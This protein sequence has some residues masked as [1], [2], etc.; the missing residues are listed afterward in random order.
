M[1]NT[2]LSPGCFVRRSGFK[3]DFDGILIPGDFG[4]VKATNGKPT[5]QDFG[6]ETW[7]TCTKQGELVAIKVSFD[8]SPNIPLHLFSPQD[9][10]RYHNQYPNTDSMMDTQSW[11]CFKHEESCD[12]DLKIICLYIELI[13]HLFY[14]YVETYFKSA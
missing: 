10:A 6:L 1:L 5:I 11:F 12:D 8:Y 3:E 4:T 7:H 9:Y 2:M 13:S 14:F